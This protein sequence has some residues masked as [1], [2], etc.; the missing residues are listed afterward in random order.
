M[1]VG[2]ARAA[3]AVSALVTLMALGVFGFVKGRFTGARP[4]LSAVQTMAIG[5]I[6]AAA[7]FALARAIS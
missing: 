4:L 1:L 6:A 3:L 2:S 7:A 5:G